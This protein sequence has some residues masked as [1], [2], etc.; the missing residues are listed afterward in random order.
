MI[1]DAALCGSLGGVVLAGDPHGRTAVRAR[2][3]RRRAATRRQAA[4]RSIFA[5][6]Q[7]RWTGG[8]SQAQ[9]D[10]WDAYAGGLGEMTGGC[11][12]RSRTGKDF[13][14]GYNLIFLNRAQ[15]GA[16]PFS[17]RDAGPAAAGRPPAA[18]AVPTITIGGPG[19]LFSGAFTATT[20]TAG[21]LVLYVFHNVAEDERYVGNPWH[22]FHTGGFIGGQANFSGAIDQ[23]G[24]PSRLSDWR[25]SA[26]RTRVKVV[27]WYDD[28]RYSRPVAGV[29]DVA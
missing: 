5:G 29:V 25:L 15:F 1:I 19:L 11:D 10:A 2:T 13:F 3:P 12:P 16:T 6:L 17:T 23:S 4:I 27:A 8:L 28:G 21:L 20:P 9:R 18:A 26:G 7:Y 22:I 24:P 14:L